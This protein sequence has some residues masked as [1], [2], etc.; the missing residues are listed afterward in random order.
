MKKVRDGKVYDTDTAEFIGE[1]GTDDPNDY[2]HE[3]EA[4]YRK[5]TGEFFLYYSGGP[6]SRFRVKYSGSS[7][8]GD[9]GI[10]PLLISEAIAWAEENI[11]GDKF[12]EVFGN[13]ENDEENVEQS[14]DDKTSVS[15]RMD[16]NAYKK[17]KLEATERKLS[18]GQL[19]EILITEEL[20]KKNERNMADLAK[21][22][23]DDWAFR[24][25]NIGDLE[26]R[27]GLTKKEK[28]ELELNLY[29]LKGKETK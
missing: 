8:R 20:Y 29:I 6:F 18:M 16:T 21:G 4:L 9:A 15:F 7:Y 25:K 2:T 24:A 10:K 5:R 26:F 3:Y 11:D 13:P 17:L 1:C 14:S 19:I 12:I 22:V 27:F 28:Q 23:Y